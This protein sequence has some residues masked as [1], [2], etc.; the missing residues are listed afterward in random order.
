M[1][2][3]PD[4]PVHALLIG[5]GDG[6]PELRRLADELH[7]SDRLHVIGRV[8]YRSLARYLA[9]CDVCLLTQTNDPSSWVRTTG[10]LP[11]YLA[12]GRY[13]LA[14]RVGTAVDVLPDEMLLDYD[15]AWDRNY[16]KRLANAI[17]RVA[18]DPG[19]AEKGWALR[20]A[21]SRFDYR[22]IATQAAAIVRTLAG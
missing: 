11:V 8:P 22:T 14:T 5:D 2:L 19:R 3:C 21:A 16:P 10:K 13:V 9:I 18:R 17:S 12:A 15:G 4:V 20:G 7:I 6:L 1:A